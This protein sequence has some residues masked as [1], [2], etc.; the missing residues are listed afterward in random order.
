MIVF[1]IYRSALSCFSSILQSTTKKVLSEISEAEPVNSKVLSAGVISSVSDICVMSQGVCR[2]FN[3]A[4]KCRFGKH[5]RFSHIRETIET[6]PSVPQ[7]SDGILSETG[8]EENPVLANQFSSTQQITKEDGSLNNQKK[9]SP[10]GAVPPESNLCRSYARNRFCRYGKRCRYLHIQL[11]KSK[12]RGSRNGTA[13]RKSG[14][15]G[16]TAGAHFRDDEKEEEEEIEGEEVQ[17]EDADLN[18]VLKNVRVSE[19][20]SQRKVCRFFRQG[21]CHYGN[22]CRFLHQKRGNIKPTEGC[23]GEKEEQGSSETP[24]VVRPAFQ[25]PHIQVYNRET[26]SEETLKQLRETELRQLKRRFPKEKL[27]VVEEGDTLGRFI[28][29]FSPTD[30]D[31]VSNS[32]IILT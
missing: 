24:R 16:R 18:E 28:I 15:V 31:W 14:Y 2:F 20:G 30:P 8:L 12:E 19:E 29:T 32:C 27:E 25:A 13:L 11:P 4:G 9:N 7:N 1:V 26:M 21:Y 10:E 22:K 3:A 6:S 5:C 23:R 17:N